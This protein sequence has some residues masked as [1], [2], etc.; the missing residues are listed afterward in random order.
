MFYPWGCLVA[1]TSGAALNCGDRAVV[2]RQGLLCPQ[3]SQRGKFKM[4]TLLRWT[5][6]VFNQ[7]KALEEVKGASCGSLHRRLLDCKILEPQELSLRQYFLA[8]LVNYRFQSS[9]FVADA[10]QSLRFAAIE[11]IESGPVLLEFLRFAAIERSRAGQLRL[12]VPSFCG[13]RR[14]RADQFARVGNCR[15]LMMFRTACPTGLT[16]TSYL[17]VD[18][19]VISFVCF[20][21]LL[22]A[23]AVLGL[24]F[25]NVS[26]ALSRSAARRLRSS[27]SCSAAASC[28]ACRW[29]PR[30]TRAGTMQHCSDMVKC[31]SH[32]P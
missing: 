29:I 3:R 19:Y 21:L 24:C 9:F 28:A 4:S 27:A 26:L 20:R 23:G 18:H 6:W 16:T 22:R 13:D 12:G 2:L 10:S 8:R 17:S 5:N 15:M 11:L 30:S 25:P 31:S 1:P 14:S 7:T 32:R